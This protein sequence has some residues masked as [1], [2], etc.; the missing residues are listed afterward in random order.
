MKLAII[1][2]LGA[3]SASH[4]L[5]GAMMITNTAIACDSAATVYLSDGGKWDRQV[6][7]T[8]VARE[9]NPVLGQTP[10]LGVLEGAWAL[11]TIANTS[12]RLLPIPTW[13][14]WAWYG[15]VA[16]AEAY[17]IR[18]NSRWSYCGMDH[19]ISTLTETT[20]AR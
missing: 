10:S 4:A 20:A 5:T 15:V 12:V 3:C 1:V 11:T 9:T 13:A 17:V 16:V 7:A 2:L 6:D 8:H 19:G 18:D 14:K